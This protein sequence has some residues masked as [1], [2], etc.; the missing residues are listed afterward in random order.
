MRCR[1]TGKERR[2]NETCT[3]VESSGTQWADTER[4]SPPAQPPQSLTFTVP[5]T[6]LHLHLHCTHTVHSLRIYLYGTFTAPSLYLHFQ[7]RWTFT[8]YAPSLY[9]HLRCTFSAPSLHHYCT[10]TA[11]SLYLL[12]GSE[13]VRMP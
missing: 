13:V 3:G 12:T 1:Q 11:L 6:S 5:S 9:L 7:L 4:E 10:F 8:F 2:C